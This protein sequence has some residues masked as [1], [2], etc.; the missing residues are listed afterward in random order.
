MMRLGKESALAL[1][2]LWRDFR[3]GEL[4]LLIV[5]VLI[6]VGSLTTVGF[7]TSRVQLALTQQSN[8]LL[9]ADLTNGLLCVDLARPEPEKMIRRIDISVRD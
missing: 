7:F 3:A 5:A 1:R 2:L 6:A 9:G 4:K 8:Q